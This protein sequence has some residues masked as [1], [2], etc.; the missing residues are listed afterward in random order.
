MINFKEFAARIDE[1]A[2]DIS[3]DHKT[4]EAEKSPWP[5]SAEYK[6]RFGASSSSTDKSYSTSTTNVEKKDGVT[7]VTRKYDDRTGE[8]PDEPAREGTP[9]QPKRGRGR[10]AGVG[11]KKGFY[12]PRDP[13]KKAESAA[14]AA[15]SK[16]ANKAAKAA[17]TKEDCD[18]IFEDIETFDEMIDM[19]MDE[20]VVGLDEVSKATL[21]SYI[22]LAVCE[23]NEIDEVSGELLG[24][25]I[26]KARK[27]RD[28]RQAHSN[29]L[30]A[31]E[32]VKALRDK[33]KGYYDTRK[34]TRDGRHVHRTKI[35]SAYAQIEKRKKKLDP[36][37]PKSIM[38]GK[39][40]DGIRRAL[41]KLQSGKLSEDHETFDEMIDLVMDE[42]VFELDEV[43]KATLG[44]Y[45][46][47]AARNMKLNAE[48]SQQDRAAA[49]AMVPGSGIQKKTQADAD[50]ADA[51]AKKREEG[52]KKAVDK[53][54]NEST[55]VEYYA[56]KLTGNL[57]KE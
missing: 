30:D 47:K 42:S 2:S 4:N 28:A 11:A 9:E 27:D 51:K 23:A 38:T 45:I 7:R 43:S 50:A 40:K 44:S 10:P 24:R 29:T 19:M 56:S 49:N 14:K 52:I 8:T 1:K 15:A 16:A 54:A 31:D 33:V 12:K 5:G 34:Y 55:A 35:D 46:K 21:G 41:D 48:Y 17:L 26:Q 53:I 3:F 57:I 6:K 25:Y 18:E 36:D 20:A 22:K 37:Y 39:R 32:K 13:A